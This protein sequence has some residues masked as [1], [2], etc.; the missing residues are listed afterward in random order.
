MNSKTQEKKVVEVAENVATLKVVENGSSTEEAKKETIL[1]ELK[2][3][4]EKEIERLLTPT[5]QQRLKSNEQMTILGNKFSFL[6][7]KQ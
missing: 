5:A 3:Q 4:Q 6:K 7:T 2:K 1:N